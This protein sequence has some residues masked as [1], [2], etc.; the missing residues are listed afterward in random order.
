MPGGQ[1][2]GEGVMQIVRFCFIGVL[3]ALFPLTGLANDWEPSSA[4]DTNL[5]SAAQDYFA[6]V[7]EERWDDLHDNLVPSV[8]AGGNIYEFRDLMDNLHGLHPAI[9][10]WTLAAVDWHPGGASDGTGHKADVAFSGATDGEVWVCGV[11]TFFEMADGTFAWYGVGLVPAHRSLLGRNSTEETRREW[12]DRP[13]EVHV[14][15]ATDARSLF[16]IRSHSRH[17]GGATRPHFPIFSSN[18]MPLKDQV[19]IPTCILMTSHQWFERP[20]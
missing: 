17:Q 2:C 5:R 9:E 1:S 8:R 7:S 3:T 14:A 18:S 19:G 16:A 11:A 4:Q 12:L 13:T 10:D 6:Q 15:D 20:K